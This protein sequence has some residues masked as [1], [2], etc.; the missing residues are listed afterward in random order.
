[1]LFYKLKA[2]YIMSKLL[3]LRQKQWLPDDDDPDGHEYC[4]ICGLL[5]G[6][7]LNWCGIVKSREA[8]GIVPICQKCE[9]AY[10]SHIELV[11]T[12]YFVT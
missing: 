1:M 12:Y 9:E 6:E 11:D 5:P 8:D 4:A 10:S 7:S 3:P 2:V